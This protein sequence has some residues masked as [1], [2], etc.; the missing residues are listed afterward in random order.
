MAMVF[1]L[2]MMEGKSQG[3]DFYQLKIYHF[4]T[5]AQEARLDQFLQQAWLPAVHKAGIS[6]VGIFKRIVQDTADKLLYVL[7]PFKSLEQF[8]NLE[9]KLQ[10]NAAGRE[11]VDAAYNDAPYL[12]IE[13]VLMRAFEKKPHMQKP[14]LTGPKNER[15]YE[16]RSYE[17]PTEKYYVNKVKMFN[18]GNEV[19]IFSRLGFNAVFYAE[20][21]SGSRMPNL[22]YMTS[23]DNKASR[24]E[25]WKA[26]SDDA[27]WKKLRAMPEYQNNVSKA[28][29]LLL[30][31]VEYSDY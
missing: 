1:C 27:D 29:I 2:V 15:V 4:K 6:N 24:D 17:S 3:R 25:H 14:A 31:P 19:G 9:R 18:D 30:Y 8:N 26:F 7:V 22:M 20:V 12:R 5:A 10:L 28:D 21:L 16:L 11:Y 13:S 23:F